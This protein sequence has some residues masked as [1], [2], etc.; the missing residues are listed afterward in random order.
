VKRPPGGRRSLLSRGA[1]DCPS[2]RGDGTSVVQAEAL[3]ELDPLLALVRRL[4]RSNLDSLQIAKE[5][6]AAQEVADL[7]AARVASAIDAA[8]ACADDPLAIDEA[9]FAAADAE[10]ANA[11]ESNLSTEWTTHRVEVYELV[12]ATAQLLGNLPGPAEANADILE[13]TP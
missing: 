9:V 5:L 3:A 7:H 1:Q 12:A 10:E 13:G 2:S 6:L 11:Q 8:A 4:V